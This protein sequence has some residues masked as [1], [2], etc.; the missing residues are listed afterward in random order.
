M[1]GWSK[2]GRNGLFSSKIG[3]IFATF[4]FFLQIFIDFRKIL[5]YLYKKDTK[6]VY[7]EKNLPAGS[8][9]IL[10]SLCRLQRRF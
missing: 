7:Y 1:G 4:R 6:E 5:G 3:V 9:R 8:C 2:T 10:V